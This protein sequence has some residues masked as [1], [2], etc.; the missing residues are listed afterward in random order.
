VVPN[1]SGTCYGHPM[2]AGDSYTVAGGGTSAV[3][4]Q[5]GLGVLL[6]GTVIFV[7]RGVVDFFGGSSKLSLAYLRRSLRETSV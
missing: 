7:P 3:Y 2:I 6:A 4:A 5:I 1:N